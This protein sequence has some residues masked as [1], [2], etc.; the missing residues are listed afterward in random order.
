MFNQSAVGLF[1]LMVNMWEGEKHTKFRGQDKY[2]CINKRENSKV[3]FIYR[4]VLQLLHYLTYLYHFGSDS[5]SFST[6]GVTK[7]VVCVIYSVG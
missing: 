1:G 5:K 6:T 7:A 2:M 3:L 4:Y